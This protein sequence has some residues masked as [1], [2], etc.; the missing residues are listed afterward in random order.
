MMMQFVAQLFVFFNCLSLGAVT[1]SDS[2]IV[3][4]LE[5]PPPYPKDS[6][7]QAKKL[8]TW[9]AYSCFSLGVSAFLSFF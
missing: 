8:F 7:M 4:A 9:L 3:A 5:L 2:R 6:S 1:I